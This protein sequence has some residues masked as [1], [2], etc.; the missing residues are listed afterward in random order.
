ME[1][2]EK[3]TEVPGASVGYKSAILNSI[4]GKSLFIKFGI[5]WNLV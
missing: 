2:K 4:E 3:K 5:Y 1:Q